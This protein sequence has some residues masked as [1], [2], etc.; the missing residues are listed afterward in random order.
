MSWPISK[1]E[2]RCPNCLKAGLTGLDLGYC[3]PGVPLSFGAPLPNIKP[4][5]WVRCFPC[6]ANKVPGVN[7][8]IGLVMEVNEWGEVKTLPSD[9]VWRPATSKG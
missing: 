1:S 8:E 4:P 5:Y 9:G 6:H 2:Y 3:T 7:G